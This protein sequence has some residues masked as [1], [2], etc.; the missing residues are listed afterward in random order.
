MASLIYRTEAKTKPKAGV[1]KKNRFTQKIR[2][3]T[4][5]ATLASPQLNRQ[6]AAL[7]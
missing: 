2:S 4:R 7:N 3:T 5:Y 6:F 1:R